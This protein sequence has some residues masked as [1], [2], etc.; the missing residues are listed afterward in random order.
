M[1][2]KPFTAE[3]LGYRLCYVSGEG[4]YLLWFTSSLDEQTGDDWNDVPW[5]CNAEEPYDHHDTKLVR[6]CMNGRFG[7]NNDYVSADEIN[8]KRLSWLASYGSYPAIQAGITL[9][10]FLSMATKY[11]LAVYQEAD[12]RS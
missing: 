9:G 6:V 3:Q 12:L 10:E 5:W 8:K 1:Q 7:P 4:P 11:G 2:L